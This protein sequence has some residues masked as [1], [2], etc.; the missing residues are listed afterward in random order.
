MGSVGYR[1]SDARLVELRGDGHRSPKPTQNRRFCL[2]P[3][4]DVWHGCVI[5]STPQP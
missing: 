5:T 1:E 2:T 4:N 3:R